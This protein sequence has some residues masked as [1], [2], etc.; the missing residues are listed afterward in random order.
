LIEIDWFTAHSQR[1]DARVKRNGTPQR[2]PI[3]RT[4]AAAVRESDSSDQSEW[5][6]DWSDGASPSTSSDDENTSFLREFQRLLF[7]N[8]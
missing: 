6:Q 8:L 3:G 4:D 1:L 2:P 5:G 7:T